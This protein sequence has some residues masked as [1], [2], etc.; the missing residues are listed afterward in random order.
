[1]LIVFVMLFLI[2]V[3]C[4]HTAANVTF[5]LVYFKYLLDSGVHLRA[6]HGKLFGYV[7]MYG[8][9]KLETIRQ[10]RSLQKY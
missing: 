10:C 3:L 1:M 9:H 7:F 5:L 8:C 2:F 4:G 6:D